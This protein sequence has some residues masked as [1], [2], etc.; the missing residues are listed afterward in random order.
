M[1]RSAAAEVRWTGESRS[2]RQ[3]RRGRN[4]GQKRGER[5]IRVKPY[6]EYVCVVGGGR[7]GCGAALSGLCLQLHLPSRARVCPNSCGGQTRATPT[8]SFPLALTGSEGG[9]SET[10][11]AWESSR[12]ESGTCVSTALLT[13]LSQRAG[14]PLPTPNLGPAFPWLR[15][16]PAPWDRALEA[17]SAGPEDAANAWAA[18]R[19]CRGGNVSSL[20]FMKQGCE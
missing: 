5:E 20:G 2:T 19:V 3:E 16:P 14:S 6:G 11:T 4:G 10:S 15:S 12:R 18:F 17:K 7:Q 13:L 8:Q 9:F 1:Q